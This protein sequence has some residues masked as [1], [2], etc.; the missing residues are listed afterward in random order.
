MRFEPGDTKTVTLV[1]IGGN[2]IIRGGNNLASGVVDLSRADEIL[3]RLQEAG[4]AYRPEPA[5]DM[6]F[7]DAFQ[8]DHASYATMFG[9]TTGDIVRL[10]S[11]DLWIKV[12]HDMTVYGDECKFGGGK[13]SCI[14]CLYAGAPTKSAVSVP[15]APSFLADS[16]SCT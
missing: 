7:I 11:T 8:M 13:K 5:G 10:G 4:Y 2:R 15:N 16:I 6:A 14:N 3:A 9:P 12:E 1:E